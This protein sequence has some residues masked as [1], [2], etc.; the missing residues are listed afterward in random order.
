MAT[1]IAYTELGGPEVLTLIE[2]PTPPPGS[3]EIV[4]RIEAAGVNP[5]DWKIRSGARASDPL[6]GPRRI[7]ADAA[8]VVTAVGAE[9]DGFRT[10][11]AVVVFGATGAYASEI[12]IPVEKAQPRP[13]QVSAEQGAALGIPVGTAYQALRS[14]AVDRRDTVLV[15]AGSGSVGQAAIQ[16]AALWGATVVATSSERRFDR[17]RELGA[18]PVAYGDGLADRVRSVAPQGVT[19]AV[20]IA[21]TDEAIQTSLELVADRERIVTL[22]R[23][24]DAAAF[25]IRAFSAGS[26]IPLSPRE[27]AWRR[28]AIPVTIALMAA[29]AFS[30][31]LGP[32]YPLADAAGAHQAV[33]DGVDGKVTL[34]P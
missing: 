9:A 30:V 1:A 31:E 21:G 4:V 14:L 13:P 33:Q 17:V 28:E 22:V 32:S 29:G 16:Y 10:G 2:V 5:I 6:T 11:D 25:G 23:G 19:V 7:G 8:G 12:V 24:K 20:D 26:P 34:I 18:I 27:L 15:H 3:G